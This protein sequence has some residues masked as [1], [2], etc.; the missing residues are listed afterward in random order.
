MPT[1][2]S[3]QISVLLTAVATFVSM[4]LFET[5]KQDIFPQIT[6]WESHWLTICYSTVTATVAAYLIFKKIDALNRKTMAAYEE[7]SRAEA[8]VRKANDELELRVTERTRELAA[9]NKE[10]ELFSASV[11]HDLRSPLRS[12]HAFSQALLED[13][14]T[15][16]DDEG[17]QFL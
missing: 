9:L 5:V 6:I 1:S 4:L 13:Y 10:L 8:E 17:R 3:F 15:A 16:L 7:R 14:E 11:A 2:K 12:I